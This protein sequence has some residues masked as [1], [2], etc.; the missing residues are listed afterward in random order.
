MNMH[1][2]EY[3]YKLVFLDTG[4]VTT[5]NEKNYV[6]MMYLITS[7]ILKDTQSCIRAV[8]RISVSGDEKKLQK[9]EELVKPTFDDLKEKK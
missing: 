7:V 3:D 4:M 5:L 2:Q 1:E 6:D 9:F 8:Q